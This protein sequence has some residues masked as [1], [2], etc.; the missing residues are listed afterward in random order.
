MKIK[1]FLQISEMVLGRRTLLG[2]KYCDIEQSETL[3][4][5]KLQFALKS[6]HIHFWMQN[7]VSDVL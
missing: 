2:L 3:D 1:T 7:H 5:Q 4:N 6:H